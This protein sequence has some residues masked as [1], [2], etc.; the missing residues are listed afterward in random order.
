MRYL[1]YLHIL[2]TTFSTILHSCNNFLEIAFCKAM[3]VD[4]MILQY[5]EITWGGGE[6]WL[7]N[8]YWYIILTGADI[9]H[10][11]MLVASGF[12]GG[13]SGFLITTCPRTCDLKNP[14][15]QWD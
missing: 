12:S 7:K 5:D 10:C 1:L 14:N 8:L 6:M 13:A 11:P 3:S 9:S 2:G 4:Q 15:L